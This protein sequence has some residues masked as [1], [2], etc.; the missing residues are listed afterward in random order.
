MLGIRRRQGCRCCRRTFLLAAQIGRPSHLGLGVPRVAGPNLALHAGAAP[1]KLS[2]AGGVFGSHRASRPPSPARAS[3]R[4][5]GPYA[6]K[7]KTA[8]L[9]RT[10]TNIAA[11]GSHTI[12]RGNFNA[13]RSQLC[14]RAWRVA[15]VQ[16]E[17]LMTK[18]RKTVTTLEPRDCRWPIGDPRQE[19]FHFCGEPQ[20]P[21][22]S[23]CSEHLRLAFQPP[24]P[25]QH[26]TVPGM[27]VRQA[28]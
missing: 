5:W 18:K 6:G 9:G 17:G 1:P 15:R 25:R 22:Q 19:D 3:A 12:Y 2:R 7:G 10:R 27:L 13:N 20:V 23:Y 26:Q 21:G 8:P 14:G 28:A 4:Q 24:R 11:A 16:V